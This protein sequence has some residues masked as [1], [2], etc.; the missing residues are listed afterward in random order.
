MDFIK[1]KDFFRLGE[2][3]IFSI[4]HFL[5]YIGFPIILFKAFQFGKQMKIQSVINKANMGDISINPNNLN[6]ISAT[7]F[8]SFKGFIGGIVF[9]VVIIIA[10][11]LIC[12]LIYVFFRY[13]ESNTRKE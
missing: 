3:D 10:W 2:N 8:D 7:W 11:K 12:E 5:Y 9:F 4:V 13:F 6:M 1:S